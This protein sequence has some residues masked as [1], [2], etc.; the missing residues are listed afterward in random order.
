M[1]TK[2]IEIKPL[3]KTPWYLKILWFLLAITATAA[4]LGWTNQLETIITWIMGIGDEA[5]QSLITMISTA[6]TILLVA[7]IPMLSSRENGA[8]FRFG[9]I[10][11]LICGIVTS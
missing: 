2:Q 4:V 9:P 5:T 7:I 8:W 10:L 3:P 6:V 1:S 11:L